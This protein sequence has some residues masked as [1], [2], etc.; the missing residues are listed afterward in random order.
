MSGRGTARPW[1]VVIADKIVA[2]YSREPSAVAEMRRLREMARGP[3]LL[4]DD[5]RVAK[6][7][8]TQRRSKEKT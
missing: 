3:K 5:F 6:I 2:R 1:C 8:A 7:P 4:P